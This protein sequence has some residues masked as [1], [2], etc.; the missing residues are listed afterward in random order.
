MQ[1]TSIDDDMLDLMIWR[2]IGRT[3][4]ALEAVLDA[5]PG[6]AARPPILP[7][8]VIITIPPDAVQQPAPT[9]FKLWE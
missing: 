7:A 2:E 8:G 4:G 5:N 6:A 9:S 1:V 3:S